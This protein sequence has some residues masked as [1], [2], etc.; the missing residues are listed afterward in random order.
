METFDGKK[1]AEDMEL[2]ENSYYKSCKSYLENAETASVEDWAKIY[3][4]NNGMQAFKRSRYECCE[5]C[6]FCGNRFYERRMVET[7][8]IRG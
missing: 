2:L 8:G 5:I 1:K 7:E 3:F 6:L 4:Q